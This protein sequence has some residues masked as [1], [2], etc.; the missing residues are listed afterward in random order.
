FLWS[1]LVD[2]F[3]VPLLARRVGRRRAWMI[4]CQALIALALVAVG[5]TDPATSVA[6]TAAFTFVVA[7]GS[8]TQDVVVDGWRIDAAP[9]DMQG[10]MAAAYQL[11]YRIA[12]LCAGAGALYIAEF[13]GWRVSYFAMAALMAIGVAAAILSPIVDRAPQAG[14]RRKAFDFTEAV[15]APLVDLYHRTGRALF[16]ILLLVA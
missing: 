1:P 5:F 12:L 6:A 9:T 11:G 14:A 7:F 10:I 3:D 4:A 15:K 8:A 2:A 16:P 13:A